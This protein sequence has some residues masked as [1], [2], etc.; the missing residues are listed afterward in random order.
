MGLLTSDTFDLLRMATDWR[1]EYVKAA[2]LGDAGDATGDVTAVQQTEKT[3]V[4]GV[5]AFLDLLLTQE[6]GEWWTK[7]QRKARRTAAKSDGQT[8]DSKD[9]KQLTALKTRLAA[10]GTT[11][12]LQLPQL[13]ASLSKETARVR[14]LQLQLVCRMLCYAVLIKKK[15]RKLLKKEIQG[16]MDRVALLLD[17]ANPPSL[18]DE[19]ADERSP[20]QEF[21]KQQL[22]PRL[23]LLLPELM[24]YLL[25][26][27]EMEVEEN[28]AEENAKDSNLLLPTLLPVVKPPQSPAEL[29]TSVASGNGS[30]LSALRQERPAKR[31]RPEAS[32]L[33]KEVTLPHQLQRRQKQSHPRKSRRVT[34]S[35]SSGASKS[36]QGS[37]LRAAAGTT[38]LHAPRKLEFAGKTALYGAASSARQPGQSNLLRRAANPSA[39]KGP[40]APLLQRAMSERSHFHGR[41]TPIGSSPG[42]AAQDAGVATAGKK[43]SPGSALRRSQT[44]SSVVMRTPDRPKR[45]AARTTRRVLVEASPPLR[46]PTAAAVPR[47]LQPKSSRPGSNP[48]PLFR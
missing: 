7:L 43:Q 28:K 16:L 32:E 20:F 22:A 37:L 5:L 30:I 29:P 13:N 19:D 3:P 47:L 33:F 10:V 15:E 35:H 1:A 4:G 36:S 45:M 21:L 2:A 23:E 38:S 6:G 26:A 31:A 24:Q 48:P 9:Q 11:L 12:V 34:N 27:Y 8:V 40:A 25:K 41:Q 39:P 18:A 42:S 17:A 14:V 46:R 44:T